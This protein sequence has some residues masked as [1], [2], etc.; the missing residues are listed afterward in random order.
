MF[1]REERGYGT[2]LGLVI[3]AFRLF[4]NEICVIV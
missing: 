1:E 4:V 3:S 2:L